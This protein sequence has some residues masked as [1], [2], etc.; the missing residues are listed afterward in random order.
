M[1]TTRKSTKSTT[2]KSTGSRAEAKPHPLV[3]TGLHYKDE[4]AILYFKYNIADESG[5]VINQAAI[6]AIISSGNS[7]IGDLA[8]IQYF[9][10]FG[11]YPQHAGLYP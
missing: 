10:W 6:F 2:G 1:K 4:R 5:C 11:G 8:L 9:D 3:G 7:T